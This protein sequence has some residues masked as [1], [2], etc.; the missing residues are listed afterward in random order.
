MDKISLT[1]NE[2]ECL[3]NILRDFIY[4][5]R[6]KVFNSHIEFREDI[7]VDLTSVLKNTEDY[8]RKYHEE[9]VKK[10]EEETKKLKSK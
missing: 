8:N 2:I 7:F 1:Y 3:L 9:I 6:L 4:E 10:L 5:I